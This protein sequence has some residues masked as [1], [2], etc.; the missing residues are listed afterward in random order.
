[1]AHDGYTRSATIHESSRSVI[2]RGVRRRDGLPV[3]IKRAAP[4]IPPAQSLLRLRNEWFICRI[5]DAPEIIRVLELIEEGDEVALVFAGDERL[6][7]LDQRERAGPMDIR[8]SLVVALGILDAL[9]V[10]HGKS[11]VHKDIK[12]G[13]ILI[14]PES[15]R[16]VLIDFGIAGVVPR[17][18]GRSRVD[19]RCEG[20][21]GYMPPEQTGRVSR[22]VDYR[23][24]YYGL[25]ATLY[26][27]LAGERPF[28]ELREPGELIHAQLTR[29]PALLD[30]RRPE[31]PQSLAR[32]VAKLLSKAAE[33]RYQ[34]SFGLRADLLRCLA[35]LDGEVPDEAFELA[36]VDP[37]ERL[38]QPR[39]L[40]GREPQLSRLRALHRR[41]A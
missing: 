36:T 34:G 38:R 11:V 18:L 29:V 20:T 9:A 27:M 14:D 31:V 41:A 32:I 10:I 30:E 28:A 40:H 35:V 39:T 23:S 17:E 24:D 8:E 5:F 37:S 7:A 12:P 25:G 21:L 13:N 6:V 3:V 15:R 1:M 2:E 33:D 16:V 19:P 4:G 26:W 22:A